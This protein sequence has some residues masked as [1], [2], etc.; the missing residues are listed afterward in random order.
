MPVPQNGLQSNRWWG[1]INFRLSKDID[2]VKIGVGKLVEKLNPS[3][4][5]PR[6]RFM[7]EDANAFLRG[8]DRPDRPD[9]PESWKVPGQSGGE[10]EKFDAGAAQHEAF[11]PA[12]KAQREVSARFKNV[13]ELLLILS[14]RYGASGE[15]TFPGFN[16]KEFSGLKD[17][18]LQKI[19]DDAA[20]AFAELVVAECKVLREVEP[21]KKSY[22]V[23]VIKQIVLGTIG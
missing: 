18:S 13:G 5:L 19:L 7:D 8:S 20:G 22:T 6:A 10:V 1:E 17:A 2:P 23:E 21:E 9:R 11:Q 15:Y 12:Q 16:L 3:I 4:G 14:T